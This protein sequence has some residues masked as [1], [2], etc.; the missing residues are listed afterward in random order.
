MPHHTVRH[1]AVAELRSVLIKLTLRVSLIDTL[2]A[3]I[4]CPLYMS[5]VYSWLAGEKLDV[6]PLSHY[7]RFTP[8]QDGE[9]FP[10]T[11]LPPLKRNSSLRSVFSAIPNLLDFD[12]RPRLLV[13]SPGLRPLSSLRYEIHPTKKGDGILDYPFM[14][15][16][17]LFEDNFLSL[18]LLRLSASVC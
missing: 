3:S 11:P 2:R 8:F 10:Q 18:S 15:F 12:L 5:F 9:I 7:A 13:G 14:I 17:L 4:P 1:R 6:F 16:V